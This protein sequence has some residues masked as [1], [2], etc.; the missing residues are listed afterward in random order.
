MMKKVCILVLASLT[1]APALA[2]KAR[3]SALQKAEFLVDSQT[4]FENPAHINKLGQYLGFEFGGTGTTQP[5]AEGGLFRKMDGAVWGAYL[6]HLSEKQVQ[7][8]ALGG[9]ESQNNPVEIFYG[10]GNW[11]A[12]VAV[13]N[14]DD[15]NTKIKE[16]S[17]AAR[18]G[19]EQDGFE[20]YGTLDILSNAET[21]T[22]DKYTGAPT[23]SAGVEKA[24]GDKYY[25]AKLAFSSTKQDKATVSSDVKEMGVELGALDRSIKNIYY[26]AFL[27]YKKI[28]VGSAADTSLTLPLVVGIEADLN[29]WAV[30][31]ASVTQSLLLAS[32]KKES[33][34]PGANSE[35]INKNDTKV[36]AGI[37]LKYANFTLDGVIAASTTGDV[38]GNAVLTQAGL[39]YAF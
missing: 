33:A 39:T 13:S 21:A 23:L 30:A 28:E 37:G 20:Y 12:S 1:A 4:I 8:R 27:G 26:G 10:R 15:K 22:G 7:Y 31:R 29:S 24:S 5:K 34:G 18:F 3:L 11:G 14:F 17:L 6:G 38:N 36:A 2:S 19:V 9:Y 35:V 16:Q 32:E 25:S